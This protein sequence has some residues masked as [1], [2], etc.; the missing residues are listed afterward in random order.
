[1]PEMLYNRM[2]A[3]PYD[4]ET[5]K[6]L[7]TGES[8]GGSQEIKFDF[9]NLRPALASNSEETEFFQTINHTRGGPNWHAHTKKAL[10]MTNFAGY[11]ISEGIYEFNILNIIYGIG[12]QIYGQHP[13]KIDGEDMQQGGKT[14]KKMG[15]N[16]NTERGASTLRHKG[17]LRISNV[18]GRRQG[19][20]SKMH[21]GSSGSPGGGSGVR[22]AGIE[23][24]WMV[25]TM[26][27]NE[28]EGSRQQARGLQATGTR[29]A[30]NECEGGR[31]W[32]RM[33]QGSSTHAASNERAGGGSAQEGGV[34]VAQ[35]KEV[36]RRAGAQRKPVGA[37]TH[38]RGVGTA[39]A[40]C[41]APRQIGELPGE[42]SQVEIRR[43]PEVDSQGCQRSAD[44]AVSRANR[45]RKLRIMVVKRKKI[46]LAKVK[47]KQEGQKQR[48]ARAVEGGSKVRMVMGTK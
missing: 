21:G 16:T 42:E 37:S 12:P 18:Q 48:G 4:E 14:E 24:A 3:E 36:K 26:A 27:G 29:V 19:H 46:M 25:R 1:M 47:S 34:G 10:K 41:G 39:T 11:S 15:A 28:R 22:A 2:G 8:R 17:P 31:Q 7:W 40:N 35:T 45:D 38:S 20:G 30:G 9:R 33:G 23:C 44:A 43:K 13:H 32:A 6:E 5:Q